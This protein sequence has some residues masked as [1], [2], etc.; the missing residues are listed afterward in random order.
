[1]VIERRR[2]VSLLCPLRL[3]EVPAWLLVSIFEG[4][5]TRMSRA[6]TQIGCRHFGKRVGEVARMVLVRIIV[7][8]AFGSSSLS[9]HT[10]DDGP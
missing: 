1:M 8:H 5:S 6:T 3:R 10:D 2:L 7:M 4:Y 9:G